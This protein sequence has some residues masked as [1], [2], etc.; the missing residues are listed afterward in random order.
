MRKLLLSFS[1]VVLCAFFSNAQTTITIG[2][3]SRT[4]EENVELP[5][6]DE[7]IYLD[8]A[9]AFSYNYEFPIILNCGDNWWWGTVRGNAERDWDAFCDAIYEW[10]AS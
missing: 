9:T 3:E 7:I 5:V 2:E 10:L 8:G 6:G 4:F 1:L